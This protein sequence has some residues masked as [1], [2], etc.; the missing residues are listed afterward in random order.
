RVI[1]L[2][3]EYV[4]NK[5]FDA[6]TSYPDVIYLYP[7]S[8]YA[9]V[10]T[11]YTANTIILVNGHGYPNKTISNGFSWKSDNSKYEY[12]T[13]CTNWNFLPVKNGVMLNCY[14]E[15]RMLYDVN[16][17]QSLQL[18]DSKLVHK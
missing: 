6:V 7:N 15:Y 8:M 18:S 16:L 2:H 12:D 1:M 9:Q 17:L 13:K 14:P 4:T 5:E 11:N 3:N 10:K